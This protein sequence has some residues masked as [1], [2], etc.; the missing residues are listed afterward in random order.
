MSNMRCSWLGFDRR[1][2]RSSKGVDYDIMAQ[3]F[4]RIDRIFIPLMYTFFFGSPRVK[5]SGVKHAWS[6]ANFRMGD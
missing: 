5:N 3:G 1:G 6:R 4:N 2:R